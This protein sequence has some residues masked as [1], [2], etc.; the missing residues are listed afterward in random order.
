MNSYKEIFDEI[1]I[2]FP[3]FI[4]TT[5]LVKIGLFS[6][7]GQAGALRARGGGPPFTR[8][9][10]GYIMYPKGPLLQWIKEEMP[11]SFGSR[12]RDKGDDS[13]QPP[14]SLSITV[15]QR[16]LIVLIAE[17]QKED[18]FITTNKWVA[19]FLEKHFAP[20]LTEEKPN[21]P[22]ARDPKEEGISFSPF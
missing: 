17:S 6:S 5:D 14:R 13:F 18:E 4:N 2:K 1:S 12:A 8:S 11:S 3:D 10:N 22:L 9:W 20:L 16:L 7:D 15:S 21:S 19:N